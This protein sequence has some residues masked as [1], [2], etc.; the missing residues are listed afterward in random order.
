M[1]F[2]SKL[3]LHFKQKVFSLNYENLNINS[4]LNISKDVLKDHIEFVT[5][6]VKRYV[7]LVLLITRKSINFIQYCLNHVEKFM[8]FLKKAFDDCALLMK[9]EPAAALFMIT[10]C[11]FVV[12]GVHYENFER[13]HEMF[14]RLVE[15]LVEMFHV[16][17]IVQEPQLPELIQNEQNLIE[18]PEEINLP[19]EIHIEE[20]DVQIPIEGQEINLGWEIHI[21]E[22]DQAL[23][24]IEEGDLHQ[25][26]N[27][28]NPVLDI[29]EVDPVPV[30][31]QTHR[32]FTGV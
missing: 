3:F 32:V 31:N 12:L 30:P 1:N 24:P 11:Y 27:L 23:I 20:I 18:L 28:P 10:L 21:E 8:D 25:P 22:V 17:E 19:W 16:P 6:F 14:N 26:I 15:R 29:E 13:F 7:D 9:Q 2:L 4:L 5:D